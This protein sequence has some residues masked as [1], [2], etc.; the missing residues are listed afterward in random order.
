[1]NVREYTLVRWTLLPSGQS[2]NDY[3]R[4]VIPHGHLFVTEKT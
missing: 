1:M 4:R 2:L 3:A